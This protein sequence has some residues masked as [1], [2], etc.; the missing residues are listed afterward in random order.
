MIYQQPFTMV[1]DGPDNIKYQVEVQITCYFI[2][3]FFIF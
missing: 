1:E 3:I 2:F